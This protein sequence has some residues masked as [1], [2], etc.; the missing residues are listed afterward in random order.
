MEIRYDLYELNIMIVLVSFLGFAVENFWLALTKGYIDNR[1]MNL[2]F[3]LGYG[4]VILGFYTLVGTP[5]D[6]RVTEYFNI[7]PSKRYI[8]YFAVSFILVSAGEILLGTF[9]EHVFGFEYWN[10]SRIPLHFT[11]YTSL[12]TSTGFGVLITLFMSRFDNIM[13]CIRSMPD[14]I[15]KPVGSLLVTLLFL[16]FVYS[17]A[18]MRRNRSLNIKWIRRFRFALSKQDDTI[19]KLP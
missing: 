15:V 19:F 8:L 17:F 2:P 4:L 12:P 6:L 13:N 14:A 9:V 18:I 10:Y 3:L 16:D 7:Y 11:K 1:N 5:D